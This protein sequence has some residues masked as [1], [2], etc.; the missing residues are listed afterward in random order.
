[1]ASIISRENGT[2]YI[3]ATINKR[4]CSV[5]LG[6]TSQRNAERVRDKIEELVKF[7]R[8][9]QTMTLEVAAWV[10]KLPNELASRLAEL[11]LIDPPNHVAMPTLVEFVDR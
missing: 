8:L 5:W 9:N 11:N 1:M 2:K 10:A 7:R 4:R 6:E 3:Q